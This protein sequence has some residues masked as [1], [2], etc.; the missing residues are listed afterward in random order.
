MVLQ[1]NDVRPGYNYVME[2]RSSEL[3]LCACCP[4]LQDQRSMKKLIFEIMMSVISD[5]LYLLTFSSGRYMRVY[6]NRLVP[7]MLQNYE[8]KFK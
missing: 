4:L 2:T 6:T 8:F 1:Q 3:L 7:C 5:Y